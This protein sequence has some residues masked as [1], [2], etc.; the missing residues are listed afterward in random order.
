M[1]RKKSSPFEDLVEITS[2]L[3]WKVGVALALVS[4]LGFDYLATLP[5]PSFVTTD[6]KNYGQT[7]GGSVGRQLM[8]TM[9]DFLQYIVAIAFLIGAGISLSLTWRLPM[10]SAKCLWDSRR[11]TNR[12]IASKF[13][14]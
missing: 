12:H 10:R 14:R 9:S 1:A 5:P 11:L 2:K 3:P 6:L 7:I 8:I 13:A 4:Y